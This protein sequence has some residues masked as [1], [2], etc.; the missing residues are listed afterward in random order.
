MF[1]GALETLILRP[2]VLMIIRN[3]FIKIFINTQ[4]HHNE[5]ECMKNANNGYNK[6]E[7]WANNDNDCYSLAGRMKKNDIR[8]GKSWKISQLLQTSS[9]F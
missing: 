7:I 3:N 5:F 6:G 9:L 1:L 8:L 2:C 4:L